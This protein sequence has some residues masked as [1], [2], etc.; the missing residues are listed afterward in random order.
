[1]KWRQDLAM[2]ANLQSEFSIR[3]GS[4][5]ALHLGL[6]SKLRGQITVKTSTSE[7]VQIALLGL[8]PFAASI[9][10]SFRPSQP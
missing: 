7:Q 9:Y 1:M 8:L 3:R 6:N 2:G 5:M 10:R 4:K